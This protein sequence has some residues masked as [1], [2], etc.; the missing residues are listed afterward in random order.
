M[1]AAPLDLLLGRGSVA[2][3]VDI[4]VRDDLSL[5]AADVG[6]ELVDP[7]EDG[8]R[9]VAGVGRVGGGVGGRRGALGLPVGFD[10]AAH[11]RMR[12]ID[13][14]A[15]PVLGV[16]P[17]LDGFAVF[18]EPVDVGPV[19]RVGGGRG[20]GLA[21]GLGLQRVDA[22]RLAGGLVRLDLGRRPDRSVDLKRHELKSGGFER[23]RG[24]GDNPVLR[25][26]VA[27]VRDVPGGDAPP[28]PPPVRFQ[29][30]GGSVAAGGAVDDRSGLVRVRDGQH[31]LSP[32]PP[33]VLLR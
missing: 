32:S 27:A 18:G 9:V 3:V 5:D 2:D 10:A 11:R 28:P 20:V 7:V 21:G 23:G 16:V 19:A 26:T 24:A 31:V 12:A 8:H 1:G 15:V 4:D 29:D 17:D 14:A 33:H 25:E 13:R 30:V 22:L 6:G